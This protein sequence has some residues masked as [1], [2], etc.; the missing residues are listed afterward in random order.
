MCARSVDAD[1]RAPLHWAAYKGFPDTL[2]LLLV[3]GAD[4]ERGDREGCAPLHWAA[5]R[6]NGEA[7]TLLL[8]ARPPALLRLQHATPGWIALSTALVR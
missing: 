5:I 1:G 3:A 4:L 2:R 6:G 7:V 8:R